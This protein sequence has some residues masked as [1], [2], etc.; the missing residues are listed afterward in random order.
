MTQLQG[1]MDTH[2]LKDGDV[3]AKVKVVS[4][5]T[6]SRIRRGVNRA[7]PETAHKLEKVTG[8]PWHEFIG[9]AQ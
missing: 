4:R 6:I 9:G 1:W 8:I 7:S 2:G 5:A 3:A